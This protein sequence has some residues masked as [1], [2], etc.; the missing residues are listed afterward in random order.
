MLIHDFKS[1]KGG[2][3]MA[4]KPF[5]WLESQKVNPQNVAVPVEFNETKIYFKCTIIVI[6]AA[7]LF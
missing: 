2:L 1:T 7:K 5:A 3:K 4:F 6:I